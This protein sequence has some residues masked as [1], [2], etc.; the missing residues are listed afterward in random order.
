MTGA[1]YMAQ[2]T[3]SNRINLDA[4]IG[5]DNQRGFFEGVDSYVHPMYVKPTQLRWLVNGV[6]SGGMVQTRPG[7]KTRFTFDLT[8]GTAFHTWWVNAG[9]PMIHPQMEAEFTPSGASQP[10]LVFA[11]SGGLWYALINPDGSLQTPQP[12]GGASFYFNSSQLAWARCV[13]T[14]T[15]VNG[16]Y[17]NNITPRNLLVIQDGSSRAVIWDGLSAQTMNPAKKVTVDATGNTLYPEGWNQTRIGF[18]MAWSGNRLW[19][20]DGPIGYASDLG[21][22]THFTEELQLNSLPYMVF[23]SDVTGCVDRGTSGTNRSQVVVFTKVSTFTLWSGIQQRLPDSTGAGGWVNTQD[24]QAKIF[25]GVGCVSGK[26]AILHRGLLY[27]QSE[28]GIVAFDSTGTVNSTQA[29]PPIDY[30]MAYSKRRISPNP[31]MTCAGIK[32]SYVFFSVPTGKVT[33]GRAYNTQTQ[34]LDRQTSIIKSVGNNGPFSYGTTGWQGIWT[35]IRPVEWATPEVSGLTRSYALSMDA[36]GVVRIWEAF[37]GNRADNGNEI[38]WEIETRTHAAQETI[39]DFAVFR[40][41]RLLL[42]QVVGN[43]SITGQWRGLRGQYHDLLTTSVTATPGSVFT[44]LAP[45]DEVNYDTPIQSFRPQTRQINSPNANMGTPTD[46][47]SAGI[48]SPFEDGIDRGFSLRLGFT[49]RAALVAYRLAVDSWTQ[50]IQGE[51]T[52]PESGF[53]ILPESGCP[54]HTDGNTPAYKLPDTNPRDAFVNIIPIYAE[55]DSYAS[56]VI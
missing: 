3:P 36:D 6:T 43:L 40:F 52:E 53:N 11:I 35:G 23:P 16:V 17:A 29:L 15:I 8:E 47:Q 26:S 42:D 55:N 33:N 28:D 10:Q 56:P 48:E 31:Q 7:Y 34:V 49:G 38:P 21:D 20:F 5:P 24:F 30:E 44:P 39:F 50:D 4:G 27:W 14:T 18:W 9:Q 1:N 54:A 37:Q 45:Y 32:S 46:C 19:I 2:R 51:V 41:F 13:Q 22:P 25:G 12:I